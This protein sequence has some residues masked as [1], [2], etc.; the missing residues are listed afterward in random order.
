MLCQEQI[1][2][3]VIYLIVLIANLLIG[4]ASYPDSY[5]V[6]NAVI[7]GGMIGYKLYDYYE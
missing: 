1:E 4:V 3:N 6:V 2:M 5:Y 7:A